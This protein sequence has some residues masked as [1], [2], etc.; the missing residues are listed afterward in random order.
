VAVHPVTKTGPKLED[1]DQAISRTDKVSVA[2]RLAGQGG[3]PANGVPDKMG[4]YEASGSFNITEARWDGAL[5]LPACRHQQLRGCSLGRALRR[6]EDG[7]LMV[8]MPEKVCCVGVGV[9]LAVLASGCASS[10]APRS[11]TTASPTATTS[12]TRDPSDPEYGP[13]AVHVST[14]KSKAKR[15]TIALVGPQDATFRVRASSKKITSCTA[16]KGSLD[17]AAAKGSPSNSVQ[18]YSI[19]CAGVS[20]DK[21]PTLLT[22]LKLGGGYMYEFENTLTVTS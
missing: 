21:K 8:R 5:R 6:M 1:E 17:A 9:L 12:P 7:G 14:A 19:T 11:A 3:T 10:S 2:V 22:K 13:G 16:K 15:L 18:H 20:D 4:Y